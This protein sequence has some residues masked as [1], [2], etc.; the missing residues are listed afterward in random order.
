MPKAISNFCP[1]TSRAPWT[2]FSYKPNLRDVQKRLRSL[3][4][5][6]A[7]DRIFATM[8]VPS[9]ALARFAQ[10]HPHAECDYPDPAERIAFWDE[11]FRARGR[12]RRLHARGLPER[13]RPRAVRR[14]AR[15]RRALHGRSG[16]RLDLVDGPAA[17]WPTGPSS[18][19][20]ASTRSIP[21]GGGTSG[22][23]R[24]L[25]TPAKAAG[26]SAISSSS[27]P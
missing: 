12:G 24:R 5:R 13:V 23:W 6:E 3:Y 18:T 9:A 17:A 2:A 7:G 26:A 20:S 22:N 1:K 8:A 19:G 11:F 14:P 15:G 16:D 27:T 4:D 25:P 10:A 21:G